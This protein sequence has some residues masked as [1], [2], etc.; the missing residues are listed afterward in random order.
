MKMGMRSKGLSRSSKVLMLLIVLI[1]VLVGLGVWQFLNTRKVPV[2][3]YSRDCVHGEKISRDMF[4]S[5]QME[6]G[7]Y[8]AL[9]G[10]GNHY[11]TSDEI[12]EAEKNGDVLLV[13]TARYTVAVSNQFVSS[14]GTKIESRLAKDMVSVELPVQKVAGLSAGVRVGSKI[15]II[16]SYTMDS[17][18][19]AEMIFQDLLIVDVVENEDGVQSV[20]VEV[21]PAESVQLIHAVTF[22]SVSAEILKPGNYRAVSPKE[23]A[24]ERNYSLEEEQEQKEQEAYMSLRGNGT[25]GEG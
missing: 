2:Y 20:Y 7:L 3:V 13:D 22:D 21:E 1:A 14:G 9:A 10:T 23:A 12:V 11:I 6:E 25:Q 18:K 5:T 24:F 4:G 15:N 8:Y 16:D 19:R 17:V